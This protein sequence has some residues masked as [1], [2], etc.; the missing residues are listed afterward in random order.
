MG[1]P[2][3]TVLSLHDGKFTTAFF[4][5][6]TTESVAFLTLALVSGLS[7][8]ET[9]VVSVKVNYMSDSMGSECI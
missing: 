2:I 4:F 7:T 8:N 1:E 3:G 9:L 6:L 5:F